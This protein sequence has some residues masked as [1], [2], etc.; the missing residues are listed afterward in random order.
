ASDGLLRLSA[1]LRLPITLG[2]CSKARVPSCARAR[3]LDM[4]PPTGLKTWPLHH[5]LCTTAC[6]PLPVRCGLLDLCVACPRERKAWDLAGTT[7]PPLQAVLLQ[8]ILIYE[9][10]MKAVRR[11]GRRLTAHAS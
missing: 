8:H 5:C 6:A 9:D 4:R 10:G 7:P 11:F 1:P 3:G 2:G